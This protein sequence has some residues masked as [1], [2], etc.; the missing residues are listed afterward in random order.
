MTMH[1]LSRRALAP[2][3]LLLASSSP[4]IAQDADAPP[5]RG[6]MKAPVA[7]APRR[8]APADGAARKA[9]AQVAAPARPVDPEAARKMDDLLGL[10]EQKS[11]EIKTLSVKYTR[12]DV[13]PAFKVKKIYEGEAKF[14]SDSKAFLDFWEVG[15]DGKRKTLDER[16]ICDG[17]KVYQ[18]KGPTKQIFVFPLPQNGQQKALQQGPLPFLFNMKA[19]EAR[20]RYDMAIAGDDPNYYMIRII[21]LLEL[22]REEYI[23]A[24]LKLDRQTLLPLA[25]QLMSPNGKDTKTFKFDPKFV[26]QNGKIL[27]AWFDA[28]KMARDAIASNA[29][30]P[31]REKKDGWKIIENPDGD[32]RPQGAPAPAVGPRLAPGRAAM[33]NN[34]GGTRP[35]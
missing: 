17:D 6:A 34:Q 32:G 16:I 22:D 3:A 15:D 23:Q 2:L 27:P 20:K 11:T 25:I 1:P 21:P 31:E 28:G 35:K 4:L 33:K 26:V 5:A 9:A 7:G 14:T 12:T 24:Y 18:F 30:L 13:V 10:W 29:A 19:G 8:T